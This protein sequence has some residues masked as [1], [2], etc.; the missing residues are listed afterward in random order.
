MKKPYLNVPEHLLPLIKTSFL[1]YSKGIQDELLKLVE[2]RII[3]ASMRKEPTL[4]NYRNLLE[5]FVKTAKSNKEKSYLLIQSFSCHGYHVAGF[6][7][8]PTNYYDPETQSYVMIPVEKLSR[9]SF[10]GL[11]N[12]YCL[13][14]FACCRDVRKLY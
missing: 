13:I 14:L 7:E 5:K 6:Q 2:D 12:A 4:A 8:V 1:C 10:T 11:S 9:D 3:K